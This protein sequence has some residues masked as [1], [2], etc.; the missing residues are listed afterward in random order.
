MNTLPKRRAH[1]TVS[2]AGSLRLISA[3]FALPCLASPVHASA[4]AMPQAV[5]VSLSEWKVQLT[6]ER[7]PP[8]LV[9]FEVRNDGTIGHAL[10]V[11]GPALEK[12]IPPIQPGTIATLKVDLR[13]GSYEVYCPV[14]NGAHKK[15]GMISHLMVGNAKS[16]SA[17]KVTHK[18][19]E[20][21]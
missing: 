11:E 10:E 19:D 13:A 20:K 6:P 12:R 7:V 5:K 21:Y 1:S 18:E 2:L 14:G 8:G 3:V 15:R 4:K 9:V 17:T 16:S